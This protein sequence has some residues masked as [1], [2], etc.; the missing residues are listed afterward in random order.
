[1]TFNGP[2]VFLAVVN[3][4]GVEKRC[5]IVAADHGDAAANERGAAV[6]P[7]HGHARHVRPLVRLTV[8]PFDARQMHCTVEATAREDKVIDRRTARAC[9]RHRGGMCT[10]G[11][12]VYLS[13]ESAWAPFETNGRD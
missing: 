13:V 8:V 6:A 5:A 3:F 11:E 4:D 2:F 7:T 1:M 10:D 9:E 12:G